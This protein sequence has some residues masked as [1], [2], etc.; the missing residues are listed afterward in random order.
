MRGF[1]AELFIS[2]KC[3]LIIVHKDLGCD[4]LLWDISLSPQDRFFYAPLSFSLTANRCLPCLHRSV[5]CD[6]D[7][8]WCHSDRDATNHRPPHTVLPCVS[9]GSISCCLGTWDRIDIAVRYP[10]V[11]LI[12]RKLWAAVVKREFI[13]SI[14]KGPFVT[15]LK[16]G[17]SLT[18]GQIA[19]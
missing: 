16:G 6:D 10:A 19:F 17:W 9:I 11:S 5:L 8:P 15:C 1:Q 4:D 2:Y 7:P 14:Q 18:V 12:K 13:C 3:C